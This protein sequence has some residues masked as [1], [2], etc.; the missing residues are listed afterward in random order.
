[1]A[2]ARPWLPIIRPATTIA[3]GPDTCELAGQRV[4]ARHRGQRQQHLDLVV[5]HAPQQPERHVAER[6]AEQQAAA[7]FAQQQLQALARRAA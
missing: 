2:S 1:M 7:R 6:Q 3:S 4:A 5:V